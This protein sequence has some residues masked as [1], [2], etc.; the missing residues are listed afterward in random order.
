M[1][2]PKT[3]NV[4]NHLIDFHNGISTFPPEDT[5]PVYDTTKIQTKIP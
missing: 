4:Y 5:A 2:L 3:T 1:I